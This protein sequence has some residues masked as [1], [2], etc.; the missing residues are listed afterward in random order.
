M[1]TGKVVSGW[2]KAE[3]PEVEELPMKDVESRNRTSRED[4]GRLFAME[5][6][7]SFQTW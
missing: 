4:R 3:H 7:I 1:K 6:K 5:S 2:A